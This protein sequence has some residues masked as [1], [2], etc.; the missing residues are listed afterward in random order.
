M[1][2]LLIANAVATAALAFAFVAGSSDVRLIAQDESRVGGAVHGSR[3]IEH[4]A[5]LCVENVVGITISNYGNVS[6]GGMPCPE[7]AKATAVVTTDNPWL[8]L[9]ALIVMTG[10]TLLQALLI[11]SE[12]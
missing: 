12:D 10:S 9:P 4:V 1:R 6:T 5:Y 7:K 11:R 3:H 8:F 2:C